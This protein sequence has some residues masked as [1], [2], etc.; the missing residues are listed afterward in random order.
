MQYR[1]IGRWSHATADGVEQHN[2]VLLAC[3]RL[4]GGVYSPSAPKSAG[5]TVTRFAMF[6]ATIGI[7][8]I[9]LRIKNRGAL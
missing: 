9:L 7:L 5:G 8:W 4:R 3:N 1:G 6:H 2:S